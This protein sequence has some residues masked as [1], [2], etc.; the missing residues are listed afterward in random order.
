MKYGLEDHIIQKI[1]A[2]FTLFP[3][4]TE[5]I[6]YGSRAK[7]NYR[8]GSDIDLSLRGNNLSLNLVNQICLKLDELML[9]YTFDI[10]IFDQ[11]E[12]PDFLD[13]IKR[14]GQIFFAPTKS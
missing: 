12:N 2:V 7:G 4:I 14:I 3:D 10:S 6:I 1:N 11:I 9:P 13:H 5:V 8:P